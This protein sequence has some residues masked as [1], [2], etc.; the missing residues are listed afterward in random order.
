MISARF[1]I[2]T[3]KSRV[4]KDKSYPK[5]IVMKR[6]A[7][8]LALAILLAACSRSVTPYEAANKHYKKCQNIR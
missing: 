4:S 7:A 2:R 5:T 1:L 6:I 8:F 3:L